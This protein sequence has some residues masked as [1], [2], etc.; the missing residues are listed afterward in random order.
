MTSKAKMRI[1]FRRV[2]EQGA[3]STLKLGGEGVGTCC[4][5]GFGKMGVFFL[6]RN[7]VGLVK[8]ANCSGELRLCGFDV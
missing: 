7:P 1:L 8:L 6:S 4:Q 3:Y 5:N 2:L